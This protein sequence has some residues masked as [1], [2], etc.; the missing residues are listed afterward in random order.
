MLWG[1]EKLEDVISA[2]KEPYLVSGIRDTCYPGAFEPEMEGQLQ[3][4]HGSSD[5]MCKNFLYVYFF[6]GENIKGF[7]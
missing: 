6:S 7:K 3:G 4:F 5:S 1:V 2:L